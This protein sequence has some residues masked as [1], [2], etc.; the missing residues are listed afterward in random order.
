VQA[1]LETKPDRK[2]K[3][4]IAVLSGTFLGILLLLT[5]FSNTMLSMTLPKVITELPRKGKL[6][7]KVEGSGVLKPQEQ[8][9]LHN[10]SGLPVRKLLAK[11]GDTVKKGQTLALYDTK[12][13]E[14]QFMD[15][16]ARLK[17]QQLAI[18]KVKEDYI[19]AQQSGDEAAVRAAGRSLE[20]QQI[21]IGIQQRKIQSLEEKRSRERELV[22]PFD[23]LVAEVMF[24]QDQTPSSGQPLLRIINADKG[25]KLEVA[26]PVQSTSFLKAGDKISVQV[27]TA[28]NQNLQLQGQVLTNDNPR[29]KSPGSGGQAAL[30]AGDPSD[31]TAR[32]EAGQTVLTIAVQ[33]EGLRG[34]EN[35][36]FSYTKP[37]VKETLLVPNVAVK[38]D[39]Q[40]KYVLV[41][42]E[43]KGPLGNTFTVRKSYFHG[44]DSNDLETAVERGLAPDTKLITES[45]EPLQEG[46][47]VRLH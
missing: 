24:D 30:P 45:S 21:D 10:A 15:E 9:E 27:E 34:G 29:P 25:F 47:R 32:D 20:S 26:I 4:T 18:E 33:G 7:H 6:E 37:N 43:N 42:Q 3:R 44:L 16:R 1:V 28:D 5:L 11:T 35:A 22:A 23:G 41:V 13:S 2:R 31:K 17:Q 12:E 8:A 19:A 14:R 38:E 36:S 40:G 46:N 39:A